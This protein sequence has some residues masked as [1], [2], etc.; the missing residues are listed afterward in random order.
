VWIYYSA[1]AAQKTV[2]LAKSAALV[3]VDEDFD[4]VVS[5]IRKKERN[6]EGDLEKR[7]VL[8]RELKTS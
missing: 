5:S 4:Y 3:T 2:R 7:Y 1:P 8:S 6:W